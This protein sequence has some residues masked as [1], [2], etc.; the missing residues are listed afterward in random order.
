MSQATVADHLSSGHVG[1]ETCEDVSG[2]RGLT[3]MG[4]EISEV[5]VARMSHAKVV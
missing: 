4:Q 5:R 2:D 3:S 1:I